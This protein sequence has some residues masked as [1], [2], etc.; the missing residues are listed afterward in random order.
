[1]NLPPEL[2]EESK[3]IQ[4][5]YFTPYL[6]KNMNNYLFNYKASGFSKLLD[7]LS[8]WIIYI[9]MVLSILIA[10]TVIRHIIKSLS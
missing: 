6:Y 3:K 7:K 10:L 2:I 1:L 8:L 5:F 4:S 9:A